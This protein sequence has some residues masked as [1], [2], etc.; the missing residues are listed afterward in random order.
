APRRDRV[1]PGPLPLNR[2]ASFRRRG[3]RRRGVARRARART[4]NGLETLS[5]SLDRL[6]AQRAHVA[7][8]RVQHRSLSVA[9][10]ETA[11]PGAPDPLELERLERS[12]D[13]V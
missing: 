6:A 9:A 10:H 8:G 3:D 7:L 13:A 2:R 1:A 5:T 4:S 11:P 12:D